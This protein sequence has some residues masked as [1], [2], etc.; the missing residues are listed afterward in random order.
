MKTTRGVTIRALVSGL[1]I[2]LGV[3]LL[4]AL[5]TAH[6][7]EIGLFDITGLVNDSG[8][9][10]IAGVS[11]I[12]TDPGGSNPD[13]GPVTTGQD[14]SYD[15]QV[16][17][18]TYDIHFSPEAASGLSTIVDADYV[19]TSD[20][21]LDVQ[22]GSSATSTSVSGVVTNADGSPDSGAAVVEAGN[23]IVATT[24]GSGSYD[25]DLAPGQYKFDAQQLI[26]N[27][28]IVEDDALV[29]PVQI[30]AGSEVIENF[31]MPDT[32]ASLTVTAV[33]Q[34]GNAASGAWVYYSVAETD[35]PDSTGRCAGISINGPDD[36]YIP[37]NSADGQITLPA[38][39]DTAILPGEVCISSGDPADPSS[40]HVCNTAP[41]TVGTTG[42]IIFREVQGAPGCSH[43]ADRLISRTIPSLDLES[44]FRCYLLQ[45]L[46]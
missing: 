45:H 31:Q 19:V 12:A 26:D 38:L 10:P 40:S 3:A 43:R 1:V 4:G 22:L 2:L 39:P 35:C 13:Y 16:G 44:V 34:N 36:G 18:G 42:A 5:P 33:D 29:D 15:L 23:G 25:Y 17:S 28:L 30:S 24:D 8:G 6:A 32:S 11:V 46:S 27:G 14:G 41:I 7:D 9:A 20:Q 21:T 37:I